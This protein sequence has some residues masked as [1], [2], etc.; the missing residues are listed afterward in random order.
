[1][2]ETLKARVNHYIMLFVIFILVTPVLVV[3][4]FGSRSGTMS[5]ILRSMDPKVYPIELGTDLSRYEGKKVSCSA[6]YLV[7]Q[8][9]ANYHRDDPERNHYADS[10]LV[11]DSNYENPTL[12]FFPPRRFEQLEDMYQR[13]M[14]RM[15]GESEI[16]FP[17]IVKGH[18]RKLDKNNSNMSFYV[19]AMNR[20]YGEGT[21]NVND[22]YFIDD[23]DACKKGDSNSRGDLIVILITIGIA[24]L[25]F[26]S[27]LIYMIVKAKQIPKMI[28]DYLV[29]NRM[30]ID[31]LDN[32]F[33]ATV[34]VTNNYWVSPELTVGY[35]SAHFVILKNDDI[36][37]ITYR[38]IPDKRTTYELK[39]REKE[40]GEC[41]KVDVFDIRAI[42]AYYSQNCP[43]III[44]E[45]LR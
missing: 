6:T 30:S 1:M 20:I 45:L 21:V 40:S 32:M 39:F 35:D 4:L 13:T 43:N 19:E 24:E 42:L 37:S 36:A 34:E 3:F 26:V 33:R 9:V 41:S 27:L 38:Y 17:I 16:I 29:K 18:V 14:N 15:N 8:V 7:S 10:Y 31:T 44:E 22:V 2:K 11:T 5:S 28:D 12:I 25:I 23:E